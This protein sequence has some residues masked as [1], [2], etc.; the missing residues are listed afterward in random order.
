MIDRNL[1]FEKRTGTTPPIYINED[2]SYIT[3]RDHGLLR[4]KR[5]EIIASGE[6]YYIVDWNKKS[7]SCNDKIFQVINGILIEQEET[8]PS[9]IKQQPRLSN[10]NV[11]V[12]K[13]HSSKNWE[14]P[15]QQKRR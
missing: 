7:I 10:N 14:I 3:R 15:H 13:P 9:S 12:R 8:S 5:K 6:K 11:T 4:E 1:V 2:L